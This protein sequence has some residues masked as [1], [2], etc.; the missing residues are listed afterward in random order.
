[1]QVLNNE[2]ID[3]FTKINKAI[4]RLLK[5][6]AE[7][8]GITDVQL[9]A[10]YRIQLHPNVGL[11]ELAEG[12]RLTNS[13]VS[14]VIDRLVNQNLVDRVTSPQDRRAITLQLT[15]EGE[16]KIVKLFQSDSI[17][18]E[19]L[20]EIQQFPPEEI[21]KLLSLHERILETLTIKEE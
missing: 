10:L 12:M 18:V 17:L 1:M 6:D 13:T 3:S 14:G 21:K 16:E 15:P 19:K 7:S 8:I 9:K 5:K 4:Y 2:I 20:N 11:S